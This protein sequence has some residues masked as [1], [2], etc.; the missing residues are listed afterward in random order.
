MND[1]IAQKSALITGTAS[2]I[3]LAMTTQ[4]LRAGGPVAGSIPPRAFRNSLGDREGRS[5]RSGTPAAVQ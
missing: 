3:G 2:G 1:R 4:I 5:P